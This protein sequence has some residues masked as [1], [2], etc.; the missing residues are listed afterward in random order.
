MAGSARGQDEA[1]L[2]KPDG[3]RWSHLVCSGLPDRDV[4]ERLVS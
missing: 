3:G 2:I 4:G 1:N